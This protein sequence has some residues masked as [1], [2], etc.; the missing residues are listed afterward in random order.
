MQDSQIQISRGISPPN[1]PHQTPVGLYAGSTLKH[2]TQAQFQYVQK[3]ASSSFSNDKRCLA[4]ITYQHLRRRKVQNQILRPACHQNQSLRNIPSTR[5][6][7]RRSN[8]QEVAA[9]STEA[10]N[11]PRTCLALRLLK[12]RV[13][14]AGPIES[15]FTP[16]TR[17]LSSGN[18]WTILLSLTFESS[19][20]FP[21]VSTA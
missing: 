6:S 9:R 21:S 3:R 12:S 15:L 18:T 7:Y 14:T 19:T 16:S 8:T 10:V 11:T 5:A 20:S 4:D 1:P 17:R 13:L 2:I